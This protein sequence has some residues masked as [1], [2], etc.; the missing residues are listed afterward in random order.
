M[1]KIKLEREYS[2]LIFIPFF[3]EKS[4]LINKIKRKKGGI[5]GVGIF[6]GS[7]LP[8]RMAV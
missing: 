6:T 8:C 3:L 5:G 7:F 4:H 1:R 2:I